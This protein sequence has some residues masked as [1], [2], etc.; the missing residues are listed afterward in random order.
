MPTET[1]GKSVGCTGISSQASEPHMLLPSEVRRE[2]DGVREGKYLAA[3]GKLLWKSQQRTDRAKRIVGGIAL[4]VISP[5]Q[6]ILGAY[7]IVDAGD[8]WLTVAC[9]LGPCTMAS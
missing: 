9:V 1:R 3:G 2:H 5:G 7:N 8:P 4:N 6:A